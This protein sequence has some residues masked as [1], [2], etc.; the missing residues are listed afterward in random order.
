MSIRQYMYVE[1]I[2]VDEYLWSTNKL[3]EEEADQEG[4]VTVYIYTYIYTYIH[5]LYIHILTYT[6]MYIILYRR[7]V[8]RQQH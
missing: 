8:M 6:H 4:G 3:E 2:C 7:G 5:T 1:Y